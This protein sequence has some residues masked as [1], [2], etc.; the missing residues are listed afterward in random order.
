MPAASSSAA[1]PAKPG[2]AEPAEPGAA[3]PGAVGSVRSATAAIV[4]VAEPM[5]GDDERR[6]FRERDPWGFILFARNC[7][8]P[9]QV[10]ALVSELRA[11]VG[12]ADAPVLVDQEGGRV[13][14]LCPPHWPARPPA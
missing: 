13:V 10:R 9:A 1:E 7:A 6:L 8:D 2:A 3:E 5:L 4:G 11:A 14:R 12:R